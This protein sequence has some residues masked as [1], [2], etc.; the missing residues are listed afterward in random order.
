MFSICGR[1]FFL[2]TFADIC[3]PLRHDAM[4][5]AYC[6]VRVTAG[7]G[8]PSAVQTRGRC[9]M[10]WAGKS[11]IALLQCGFC[12]QKQLALRLL[13]LLLLW[14]MR[15]T[16]PQEHCVLGQWTAAVEKRSA[17][18]DCVCESSGFRGDSWVRPHHTTTP[19]HTPHTTHHHHQH[20][21]HHHHHHRGQV[22][23]W[24]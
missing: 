7:C 4:S 16:R 6:W 21:H 22:F 10:P 8:R 17:R 19:P 3:C 24:P 5:A 14:R 9:T 11:G 12:G 2:L 15:H 23:V 18:L 1:G 20:T 13:G